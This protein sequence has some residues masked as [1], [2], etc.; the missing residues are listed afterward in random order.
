MGS[1]RLVRRVPVQ[2]VVE[3]LC[4]IPAEK[5]TL[6]RLDDYLTGMIL[7]QRS[8]EPFLHFRDNAYTRNLIFRNELFEV[9][10][11]CWDVG[12]KTPIHNHRGQLGWMSV[13]QGMLSILNYK[14][15][16]CSAACHLDRRWSKVALA[17]DIPIAGVGF[18]AH[19]SKQ[20]T[21]HQ[22]FNDPAF[23]QRAVSLHIYSKP[24]DSCVVYDEARQMCMDKRL[25]NYTEG[26]KFVIHDSAGVN[27]MEKPLCADPA[28]LEAGAE[29]ARRNGSQQGG[30]QFRP[31][32]SVQTVFDPAKTPLSFDVPE[33]DEQFIIER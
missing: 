3:D 32:G 7:D 12:Q 5:F 9:L 4:S 15:L 30:A 11:L 20:E 24:F 19:V 14:R 13:Q 25:S 2:E 16:D 33:D 26:G 22:I 23:D 1:A 17:D 18:V 6:D 27:V 31:G 28:T 29:G 10:V 21:I 8:L